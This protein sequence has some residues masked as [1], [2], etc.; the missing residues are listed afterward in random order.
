MLTVYLDLSPRP[1]ALPRKQTER[2]SEQKDGL[3]VKALV[4]ELTQLGL[5]PIPL[6]SFSMTL[7]KFLIP[8]GLSSLIFKIGC[9]ALTTPFLYGLARNQPQFLIFKNLTK[10]MP[11]KLHNVT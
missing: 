7:T 10:L 3:V 11:S 2:L 1:P 6:T 5:D 8:L 4:W 9:N